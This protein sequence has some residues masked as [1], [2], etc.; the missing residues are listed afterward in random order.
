MS[1]T[2]E[3]L[4]SIRNAKTEEEA[5]KAYQAIKDPAYKAYLAIVQPANK[6]YNEIVQPAWKAYYSWQ[7]PKPDYENMSKEELIK[8]I[9][10]GK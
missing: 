2:K 5:S 4:D 9:K 3:Q 7:P 10:G 8:I 1:I 6:A